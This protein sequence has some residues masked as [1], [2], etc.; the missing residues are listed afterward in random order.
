MNSMLQTIWSTILVNPLYNILA[1]IVGII[2]GGD[3]GV[4]IILLTIIVK[5][6]LLP[7]SKKSIVSQ[8]KLKQLEPKIE[9]I[10]SNYPDKTIQAQKTFELY[11]VEGVNPFSGCLL[12][13]IQLP[14]ILA[15]F[16]L[17]RNGITFNQE[18][19]YS[20]IKF[21]TE[22]NSMFLGFLDINGKSIVLA[23]LVGITQYIQ[24]SLTMSA[25]KKDDNVITA[26]K[27]DFQSDLNKA[28]QTQ[29]K[30]V[31]PVMMIFFSYV[32]TSIVGLYFITTNLLTL[33]QEWF[34]RRKFVSK[35]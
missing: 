3:L 2:P 4:A 33:L 26:P 34:I 25:T 19:L 11:K 24:I 15:L 30:Y 13:L 29:M 27:S 8:I 14:L 35:I 32:G 16:S 1:Y 7:L 12:A 23:L 6:I 18:V 9:L 31:L 5:I 20:F 10:K 22:L 21:P 28:M 17:F